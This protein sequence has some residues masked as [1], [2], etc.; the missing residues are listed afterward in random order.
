MFLWLLAGTV[1]VG[2]ALLRVGPA[3]PSVLRFEFV[4][5]QTGADEVIGS[6]S[7]GQQLHAAFGLGL[8]YLFMPLYATTLALACV[9]VTAAKSQRW[10]TAGVCCAW[11]AWAAALFDALENLALLRLLLGPVTDS[12]AVL[13]SVCATAK[14]ALIAVALCFVIA[15]VLSRRSATAPATEATA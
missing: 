10:G 13:A 9:W 11:G 4:W 3:D 8:D 7:T 5:S 15:A 14:F 1:L 2:A 12:A 6:W